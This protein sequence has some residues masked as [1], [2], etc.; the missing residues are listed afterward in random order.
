MESSGNQA[1]ARSRTNDGERITSE[2]IP[3]GIH[4]LR[5]TAMLV[6]KASS[7]RNTRD[8]VAI[9]RSPR[10]KLV[11]AL[12]R[13]ADPDAS[14]DGPLAGVIAN[15]GAVSQ[16]CDAFTDRDRRAPNSSAHSPPRPP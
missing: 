1:G 16:P 10:A 9:I 14:L 13:R 7:K 12:K 15:L 3:K 11:P 2:T 6:A 8:D 4:L 5:R